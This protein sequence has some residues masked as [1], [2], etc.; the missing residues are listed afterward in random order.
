MISSR[1][2]EFIARRQLLKDRKALA[3]APIMDDVRE[4]IGITAAWDTFEEIAYLDI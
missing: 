4:K 1:P 2:P 3:F